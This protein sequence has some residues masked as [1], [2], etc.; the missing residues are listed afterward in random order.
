M[1]LVVGSFLACLLI[2]V[3]ASAFPPAP[4]HTLFGMVRNQWGDPINMAD[5]QVFLET[6]NG[7]GVAT[8]LV[9]GVEPDAN[10]RLQVP[11]DAGITPDLYKSTALRT[12]S[13]FRLRVK[14]GQTTYL[15]IEMALSSP[16]IGQPAQSTRLDLTLGEDTDGDGLPDAWERAL[17]AAL[18]GNLTLADI[19]PND[20]SDG[21]GTSN[22]L[23]YLSGTYA[24]DPAEGFSLTL[25]GFTG[26]GSVLELLAIRGRT[27]TL[28][29]SG[30]LQQWTPV[31]FRV[32]TDA[33]GAPLRDNYA[34][35]E[36]RLLRVE[37]P[38]Q[39]GGTTNSFFKAR[40]Q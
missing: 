25:V 30:D 26:N 9:P 37:V 1:K 39:P 29:A 7:P 8:S 15:P 17:I 28:E 38:F 24:F 2:W 6:T 20:D 18:G 27:Y 23:E 14:I 31:Q 32:V 22:L 19:R 34:A 11:L 35:S 13:P 16:R 4:P 12:S 10:Y 21:D 40:V 5:A 36:L 3:S 33:P